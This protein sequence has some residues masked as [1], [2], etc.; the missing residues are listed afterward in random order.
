MAAPLG[1]QSLR[2]RVAILLCFWIALLLSIPSW[3]R[4]TTIERLPLSTRQIE[5]LQQYEKCPVTFAA[6]LT[7]LVDPALLPTAASVEESDDGG[8]EGV[9]FLTQVQQ[10]VQQSLQLKAD[11]P[12]AAS[13]ECTRWEVGARSIAAAGE[14]DLL[15]PEAGRYVVRVRSE[16]SILADEQGIQKDSLPTVYLP[17]AEAES[18]LPLV[19]DTVS[20]AVI[21]EL[22]YLRGDAPTSP[23]TDP[24]TTTPAD[25]E[26]DPRVIQYSKHIRLVFSIM[27]QDVTDTTAYD[28]SLIHALANITAAHTNPIGQLT[29]ELEGLH[30][31]HVETQV[32][33]FAPLAFQPT[34]EVLEEIVEREVEQEVLVEQEV[35]E[36]VEIE[37]DESEPQPSLSTATD[38]TS[39]V[40]SDSDLGAE[41]EA[42]DAARV[43]SPAE[44]TPAAARRT[45]LVK[46]RRKIQV[47]Q[48]QRVV[49]QTRTPLPPRHV[50]EWDDLKVFVN[51][52]AWALT[53]T[54]P[55]TAS[56]NLLG[57]RMDVLAQTHDLH[58][59]LYVP[60]RAHSPLLLR[61][62]IEGDVR[63]G[64]A[65]LIPQWGG[66]VILN[67][68]H[69]DMSR[70][71][72]RAAAVYGEQRRNGVRELP[73]DE[74]R[75]AIEVF[76][77]QL[78]ILLGLADPAN[79]E[80]EKRQQEWR[81]RARVTSLK[82]RRIL[83]LARE[84]ISTLAAITRLVERID[85]LGIGPA[86]QHDTQVALHLLQPNS[87]SPTQQQGEGE[88]ERLDETLARIEQAY[89]L[90]NRAFFNPS[91]L[92]LLYFPDEHK[93]AVYTPL[94]APLLVPLLVSTLKILAQCK[95][96]W[97]ARR[98][99]TTRT[100]TR[101]RHSITST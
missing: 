74:V 34:Q 95:A 76:K 67:A 12:S 61:D 86:V 63:E 27:N 75:A 90:S 4:L 20:A 81:R 42:S 71:A 48:T 100:R 92:G 96:A 47:P 70:S 64:G 91:M 62:P 26:Q 32:Q 30:E 38:L 98:S 52:E 41:G 101:S 45:Q 84:S 15:E 53:S 85:N 55:P 97:S 37:I 77:R 31:F 6:T 88:G 5:A 68:A 56:Q 46:R 17:Q 8:E 40:G 94:F 13:L 16:S 7:V 1:F 79:E 22:L 73:A 54:V 83:E 72:E 39:P 3:L 65:W 69:A 78:E 10:L 57:R 29:K 19:P 80:Q 44:P 50:V 60:S 51:S 2:T 9:V 66:V 99:H 25:T 18:S 33:W 87:T 14:D 49:Q 58:F 59:V 43:E 35:E 21:A 89:A 24:S 82:Q 36:E 93:Y 28:S 23:S 11:L